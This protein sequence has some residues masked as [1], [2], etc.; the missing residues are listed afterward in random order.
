M[1]FQADNRTTTS[2]KYFQLITVKGHAIISLKGGGLPG[3]CIFYKAVQVIL[4][5]YFFLPGLHLF[6]PLLPW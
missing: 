4:S 6:F 5:F 3:H 2:S 1:I